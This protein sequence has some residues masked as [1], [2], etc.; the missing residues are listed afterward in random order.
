MY[1]GSDVAPAVGE[2]DH[3]Y[4]A[5][6][7]AASS[8]HQVGRGHS[9]Y[10]AGDCAIARSHLLAQLGETE[11]ADFHQQF[12][13]SELGCG[14]AMKGTLLLGE[15]PS[16]A[17][18]VDR[19][20]DDAV[21]MLLFAHGRCLAMRSFWVNARRG[22]LLDALVEDTVPFVAKVCASKVF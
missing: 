22:A 11:I 4:P 21:D 1:L 17:L 10:D 7:R 3:P 18:Q 14:N 15:P 20:L 12:D 16:F 8:L 13:D 6:F 5:I 19:G 2:L 9:V